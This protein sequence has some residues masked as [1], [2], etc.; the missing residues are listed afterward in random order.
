MPRQSTQKFWKLM[1][2]DWQP[3]TDRDNVTPGRSSNSSAQL[4]PRKQVGTLSIQTVEIS[5]NVKVFLNPKA[6]P[7]SSADLEVK[8]RSALTKRDLL[9]QDSTAG[10]PQV[11]LSAQQKLR[12]LWSGSETPFSQ[13]L[14]SGIRILPEILL[15]LLPLQEDIQSLLLY[16]FDSS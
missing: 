1:L 15:P 2:R 5:G 4:Q 11:W 6:Q 3:G 12:P 7:S 8:G 10:S 9:V 16:Q 13:T 14:S